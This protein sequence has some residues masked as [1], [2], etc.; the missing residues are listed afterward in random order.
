MK[1]RKRYST[2]S[3]VVVLAVAFL[4]L[5]SILL[6]SMLRPAAVTGNVA[7]AKQSTPV[8]ATATTLA[9]SATPM[10]TSA[11]A[12]PAT[13]SVG[14]VATTISLAAKD[15]GGILYGAGTLWV[16]SGEDK[17]LIKINPETNQVVDTIT[18]EQ[19]P[20]AMLVNDD[21]AWMT[22]DGGNLLRLDLATN[23]VTKIVHVGTSVEG[24]VLT[25]GNLWVV[26][27]DSSSIIRI[28]QQAGKIV[29]TIPMHD[30]TLAKK[31]ELGWSAIALRGNELWASDSHQQSIVRVDTKSNKVVESIPVGV[32]A[33]GLSLV[34]DDLWLNCSEENKV[35]RFD[36]AAKKIVTSFDAD[37]PVGTTATESAVWVSLPFTGEVMRIDPKTNRILGTVTVFGSPQG[38]LSLSGAIWVADR[39]QRRIIKLLPTP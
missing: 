32:S 28:D 14:T 39:D 8:P 36:L 1:A 16:V 12:L 22:V 10:A 24:M 19:A 34:G 33:D 15:P 20:H 26:D 37:F 9:A 35:V 7:V 23:K 31:S 18:L 38:S 30:P 17:L 4:A 6:F 3:I 13:A 25:E 5:G 11:T 21:A 2:V 27:G 29:A